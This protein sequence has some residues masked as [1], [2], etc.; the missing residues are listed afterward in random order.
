MG[1]WEGIMIDQEIRSLSFRLI[2]ALRP[3]NY[4]P[5]HTFHCIDEEIRIVA[6]L[7]ANYAEVREW[8]RRLW[9]PKRL[10][11]IALAL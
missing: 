1:R 10:H 7:G 9:V 3:P 11:S 4:E 2:G 8:I 5:N 6:E